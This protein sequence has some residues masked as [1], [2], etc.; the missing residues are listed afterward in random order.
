MTL[1]N[2]SNLNLISPNFPVTDLRGDHQN[3]LANFKENK[4]SPPSRKSEEP[5]STTVDSRSR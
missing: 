2:V 5:Q 4:N 3:N 1:K